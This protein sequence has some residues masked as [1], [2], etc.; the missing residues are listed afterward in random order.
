MKNISDYTLIY[1]DDDILVVNKKSGLLVASD[2]YDKDA[3][4]LDKLVE[5]DYGRVLAVHRIDKDTSGLVIYARNEEAHRKLSMAFEKRLVH[6]TYHALVHGRP[7]WDTYVSEARLLTDGDARHR[8][9][10]NKRYGKASVTEFRLIGTCGPFS[11]IEAKPLTGRTHQIRA[12]LQ[13]LGICIVCDPLYSGNQKPV[14]LSDIKRSWRGDP[15]EERPL[16][17]RLALH[18]YKLQLEHPVTGEMM[19]FTAPYS[20]DMDSLRKQLAKLFKTDPLAEAAEA[21]DA[22]NGAAPEDG[23]D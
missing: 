1:S 21:G 8:T 15:F 5:K 10:V 19:E 22:G 16:L 18:A 11:W 7:A 4:R 12:H 6:K 14:K 9:V 2:R 17:S 20:K 13:D 3:P 23:E